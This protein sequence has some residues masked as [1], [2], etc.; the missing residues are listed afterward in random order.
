MLTVTIS[1][2]GKTVY[3]RSAKNTGVGFGGGWSDEYMEYKTDAGVS[4]PHDPDKGIIK[5]ATKI[6]K[7]IK[8]V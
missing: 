3:S 7:T 5:L 4:I 8:E 2:N 6:L 1:V